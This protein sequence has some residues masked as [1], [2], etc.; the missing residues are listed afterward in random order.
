MRQIALVAAVLGITGRLP[1]LILPLSFL[2]IL[3]LALFLPF[4]PP[5]SLPDSDE[6]EQEVM[7]VSA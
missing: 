5:L 3:L 7:P 6:P 4:S 2:A 1:F